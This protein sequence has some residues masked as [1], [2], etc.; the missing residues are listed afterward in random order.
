MQDHNSYLQQEELQYSSDYSH[1]CLSQQRA[2][3]G[4]QKRKAMND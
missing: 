2:S 1:N 4:G 3:L